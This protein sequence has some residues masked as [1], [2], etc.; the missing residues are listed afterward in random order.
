MNS[1]IA[2]IAFKK[3]IHHCEVY[4]I[5]NSDW[6]DAAWCKYRL[7]I[8][9]FVYKIMYSS[10]FPREVYAVRYK[11]GENLWEDKSTLK[12]LYI[13]AATQGPGLLEDDVRL[14]AFEKAKEIIEEDVRNT[15]GD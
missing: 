2:A 14:A 1:N 12:I 11:V 4:Y 6:D 13:K 7:E 3:S 8:G 10:N 9:D 5:Y 15:F